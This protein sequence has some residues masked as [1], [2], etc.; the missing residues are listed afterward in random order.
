MNNIGFLTQGLN[1]HS[2]LKSGTDSRIK[3]ENT[4][5]TLCKLCKILNKCVYLTLRTCQSYKNI[6]V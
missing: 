6:I 2:E 1:I 5:S 4:N 3:N